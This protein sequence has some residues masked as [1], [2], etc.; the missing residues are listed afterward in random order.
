MEPTMKKG[1]AVL[2]C[3]CIAFLPAMSHAGA[4]TTIPGFHKSFEPPIPKP[5]PT[6]GT[7][8]AQPALDLTVAAKSKPKTASPLTVSSASPSSDTLPV[9]VMDNSGNIILG[10]GIS[11]ITVD[12]N[13][14][15]MVVTQGA[16]KAIQNWTS[17]NIGAKD[18]V[19]FVQKNSN[20]VCLNR[21]FDQNASQILGKLKA[22]GQ[23]YLINQNGILFGKGSQVNVHTMIASSLNILD[24]DFLSGALNFQPG[25]PGNRQYQLSRRFRHKPRDH[26][27]R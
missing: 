17:F 9:A 20:Y 11:S 4:R 6:N 13:Q 1:L 19:D 14:D 21:I 24:S 16:Q 25:L 10:K 3:F 8:R 7:G 5:K 22:A 26:Y 12:S 15:K 18:E 27:Y 23:V 2:L